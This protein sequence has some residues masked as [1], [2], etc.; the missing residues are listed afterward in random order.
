MVEFCSNEQH[1][2]GLDGSRSGEIDYVLS[3]WLERLQL[4]SEVVS[5]PQRQ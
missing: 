2:E 4:P 1:A 5:R 3:A